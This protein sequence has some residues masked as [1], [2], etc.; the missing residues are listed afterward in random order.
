VL[1]LRSQGTILG[2][3][4]P[5]IRPCLVSVRANADHRFNCETHSWFCLPN[6]LVLRVVRDI[7]CAVE[8]LVDTVSAVGPDYA[9]VLA[10]C[11]FLNDITVFAEQRAWLGNFNSLV[12]TFTCRLGYPYRVWVRQCL[13][14]NIV[15][16]VQ[17]C[18]ETAVIDGNVDVEDVSVFQYSLVG[19]AVANDLVKRRA[20]G[21]WKVAVVEW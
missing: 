19:N 21:L 17:V 7:G 1:E 10:L 8:K 11:M 18:V 5:I 6:C 16:F 20:Y 3:T 9:A 15:G 4:R 12:Q 14:S 2:D 13:V